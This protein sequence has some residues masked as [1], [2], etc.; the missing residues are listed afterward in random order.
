M[1][2]PSVLDDSLSPLPQA[3]QSPPTAQDCD[4]DHD[5]DATVSLRS[6]VSTPAAVEAAEKGAA[7]GVKLKIKLDT[8]DKE[9][10][11]ILESKRRHE[12]DVERHQHEPI[13]ATRIEDDWQVAYV[14][15]FIV[16]FNLRSRITRLATL[17][18]L[19]RCLA[20]P[21][22]NRPDDVLEGILI[23]FL[24]NLKPGSRNLS[25][26]NI[27]SQISNYITET[28]T[29][30]S[31]W[32]VW[33]RTWPINEEDRG[34]CC[35]TDPHRDEL[36]RLRYYGE[37]KSARAKLNPLTKI[38]EQGG[39]LFELE[40][41]ERAK[42]LR[43][44]VDWQLSH[45]ESI[46][47]V[48]NREFGVVE[49]KGK[50]TAEPA[51]STAESIKVP[52]LGL[53]R[54][55]ARVWGF[56]DSWRL[57]KSGNP[58]KRPCAMITI[59][60]TKEQYMSYLEDIDTFTSQSNTKPASSGKKEAAAHAKLARSIKEEFALAKKLRERIPIIEQEELRIQKARRKI[61]Q[62]VQLHQLAELRST[63]TRR[64]SRKVDYSYD[65][66]DIDDFDEA[67]PSKRNRR[68]E[69]SSDGFDSRGKP[70]I[71]G[72]RRSGRT[73]QAQP[74]S[75]PAPIDIPKDNPVPSPNG[76]GAISSSAISVDGQPERKRKKGMKGY[77]WVEEVVP[78]ERLS[79]KE[80][81]AFLAAKKE[82]EER[83]EKEL[84]HSPLIG[85]KSEAR[86][87][88]ADVVFKENGHADE[89]PKEGSNDNQMDSEEND[90][91]KIDG[92]PKNRNGATIS[93]DGS[94]AMD[95]DDDSGA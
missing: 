75:L 11:R 48:I 94:E 28:L 39:G 34:E 81:E 95:I 19:E 14:W 59:I 27:Q 62:V 68:N 25:C 86:D 54:D 35:S 38:E 3:Q 56:D 78:F 71:P 7:D 16:K 60:S 43:Q 63:R 70:I 2:R 65:G 91:K 83:K 69:D 32:T 5:H 13:Q 50:K 46:R 74:Q 92:E 44:L 87:G 76:S 82:E 18:D 90:T 58:Y 61:A 89:V 85:S 22:A 52:A 31:E 30:T 47:S 45:S 79:D 55:R 80:K 51:P 88:I 73:S 36:G 37:P 41:V 53:T 57:W 26:E 29:N 8:V 4:H 15:S 12:E 24:S 1:S 93:T 6:H 33:D 40:W 9:T 77:A 72:E 17:E 21:V 42:L 20:E 66:D 67:G 10:K 64:Q 23:C 49:G 84:A